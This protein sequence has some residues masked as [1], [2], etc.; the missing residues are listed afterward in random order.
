MNMSGSNI[1]RDPEA[2]TTIRSASEAFSS[3]KKK[4]NLASYV[5][6]MPHCGAHYAPMVKHNGNSDNFY[7]FHILTR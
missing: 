4:K 5:P 1:F 3:I 6:I 7:F 2:I